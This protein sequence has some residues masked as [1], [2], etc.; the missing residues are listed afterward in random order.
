MY[1]IVDTQIQQSVQG[2]VHVFK[3]CHP[4]KPDRWELLKR[5]HL[6]PGF[7]FFP[8]RKVIFI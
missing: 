2:F 1:V 7:W 5:G 6:D 3:L 8:I 4:Q